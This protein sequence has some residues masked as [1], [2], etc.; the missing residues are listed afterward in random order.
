[1]V[2][3]HRTMAV[4]IP[5]DGAVVCRTSLQCSITGVSI[6]CR[7][8]ST[9]PCPAVTVSTVFLPTARRRKRPWAG[10][11][12]ATLLYVHSQSPDYRTWLFCMGNQAP[13]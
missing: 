8:R 4:V 12:S 5:R 9:T 13:S 10:L 7:S 3:N 6:R 1:V 2:V 11:L